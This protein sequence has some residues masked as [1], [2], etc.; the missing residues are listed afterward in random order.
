MCCSIFQHLCPFYIPGSLPLL[1]LVI[2]RTSR[3]AASLLMAV[4]I[5]RYFSLFPLR[6]RKNDPKVAR[7]KEWGRVEKNKIGE[8]R[9]PNLSLRWARWAREKEASSKCVPHSC[10]TAGHAVTGAACRE[11]W[12]GSKARAVTSLM[13]FSPWLN[14]EAC[15]QD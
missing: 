1:C 3:R 12:G 8:K 11:R 5:F 2:W 6:E 4:L 9:E 10:A 15:L 7:R 13:C 14:V